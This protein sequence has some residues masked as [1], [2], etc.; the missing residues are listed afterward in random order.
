MGGFVC[1][2]FIFVMFCNP[3]IERPPGA[4][5]SFCAAYQRIIRQEHEGE[6]LGRIESRVVR[7]RIAANETLYRCECE[8]W[9]HEICRNEARQAAE[10]VRES[11]R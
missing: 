6:Q 9:N 11:V 2:G 8:G 10:Q 3:N 4:V 5:N 1:V 7:E